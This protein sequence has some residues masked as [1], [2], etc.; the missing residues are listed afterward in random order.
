MIDID[1]TTLE[2]LEPITREMAEVGVI[3]EL[4]KHFGLEPATAMELY[5][6]SKLSSQIAEGAYGIQ[7]MSAPYLLDDL[8]RNEPELFSKL[9]Q[10]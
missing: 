9:A 6:R 2:K 8:L 5:Y 4:A 7:Y 1:E 10:V 3:S